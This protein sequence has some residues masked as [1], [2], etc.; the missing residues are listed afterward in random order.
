M[1]ILILLLLSLLQDGEVDAE[2]LQR[3]LTQSGIS[4]TY[5]RETMCCFVFPFLLHRELDT[6]SKHFSSTSKNIKNI[7]NSTLVCHV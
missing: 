5:A 7:I 2:E 3:C 6:H 1:D 4:G